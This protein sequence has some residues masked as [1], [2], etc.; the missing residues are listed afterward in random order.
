MAY[1][2]F[3]RWHMYLKRSQICFGKDLDD[4]FLNQYKYNI[5]MSPNTMW[6]HNLVEKRY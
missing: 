4:E 6:L 1:V 3:L 5:Y 2:A